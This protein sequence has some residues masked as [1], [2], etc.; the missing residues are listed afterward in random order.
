MFPFL[1]IS[2]SCKTKNLP[3]SL[4]KWQRRKSITSQ[5]NGW[6]LLLSIWLISVSIS[7]IIVLSARKLNYSRMMEIL[8]QLPPFITLSLVRLMN[9]HMRQ[10][11]STS[12][13]VLWAVSVPSCSRPWNYYL[14]VSRIFTFK[15]VWLVNSTGQGSMESQQTKE[16]R[17]MKLRIIAHLQCLKIS[18]KPSSSWWETK[19]WEAH[20]GTTIMSTCLLAS[21]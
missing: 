1:T 2:Q 13:L 5:I 8:I 3:P 12:Y 15:T 19:L 18:K 4:K 17:R 6:T 7:T 11:L 20:T 16:E 9:W 14:E 21:C 10:T